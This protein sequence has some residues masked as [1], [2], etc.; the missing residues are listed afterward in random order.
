MNGQFVTL[1]LKRTYHSLIGQ[2]GLRFFVFPGQ[3]VTGASALWPDRASHGVATK[4][5]SMG[6]VAADAM[7]HRCDCRRPREE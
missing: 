2:I 3:A 7:N 5:A 4:W 1:A 6:M